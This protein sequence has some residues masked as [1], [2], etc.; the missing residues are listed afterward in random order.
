MPEMTKRERIVC[1]LSRE[2]PDR[3]PIYDLVDHVGIISRLAG[4]QLT[5]ANAQVLIPRALGKVLDTTRVWLPEALGR[6]VDSRGFVYE[7][8]DWFNEWMVDKPYHDRSGLIKYIKSDIDQL[9]SWRPTHGAYTLD[10]TRMWQKKFGETVIPASMA[11]E[12]LTDVAILIGIDEFAYLDADEP[13]LVKRWINAHHQRTMRSLQAEADCRA[14]SPVGWV[15]ADCA[16]NH[17][18][19]FSK[20]FLTN[21]GFFQRLAE[22]M[23]T[24]HHF[25]LKIIF[26]SDGDI[27]A[28][29][30]ELILAGAD[31]LAPIDVVAGLDLAE[32]KQKYGDKVSF[33]G[34]IDIGLI[35]SATPD[36]IRNATLRA[37]KIAAPGG[38]FILGSSSEELYENLPEENILAMWETTLE[39]GRYPISN[40]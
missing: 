16:F 27:S 36:E 25:G 24:M 30:P 38:G 31:A 40:L 37:L 4:E 6:R 39:A 33:V 28:I 13:Q 5:L 19:I 32:L 15:F 14:I 12:A 9:E 18:L 21:H 1:A 23:S 2:E 22:I 26:H 8:K 3:V 34:G 29:I 10:E 35:N 11:A 20:S 7:R 17:H